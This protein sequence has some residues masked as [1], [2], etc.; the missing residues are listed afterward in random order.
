MGQERDLRQFLVEW[1][2]PLPAAWWLE[3]ECYIPIDDA[4]VL[5]EEVAREREDQQQ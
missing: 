4:V 1:Q 2:G 3:A 5:L